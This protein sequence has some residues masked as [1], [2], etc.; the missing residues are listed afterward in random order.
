MLLNSIKINGMLSF[1]DVEL[2]MRPLNVLVGPNASGKSNFIEIM[3]LLQALPRDL[4]G[5][6]RQ[7]GGVPDWLWK[8][9]GP[10]SEN[11]STCSVEAV[12]KHELN[13]S[14][15]S[16]RIVLEK[17]GQQWN[18]LQEELKEEPSTVRGQVES[19]DLVQL[20]DGAGGLAVR[21]ST[22]SPGDQEFI[23][24]QKGDLTPGQSILRE[25]RDP[26][27][28]PEM[29][30]LTLQF[31]SIRLYRDWNMGRNSI[32]RRPQPTDTP[33]DHLYEDFSN[34]ALVLNRLKR[35]SVMPSVDEQL[36]RF[37]E[38][39][40]SLGIDV[41]ANTAQLW[42]REKGLANPVPATRLSDG[43]LR[44]LALLTI[45]CHPNPP[46]LVCI[47]EPELGLHPD[48]IHQVAKL[49]IEASQRTQLIVTTHSAELIDH[50]WEDPESVVVCERYPD[51]GTEFNRLKKE[52]LESYLER[53][54][55]GELWLHGHIG[56]TRF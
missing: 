16:Y 51:T 45:L 13:P 24:I 31:D 48:V 47:E 43:T 50:L 36:G 5:F 10:L 39:Y 44:F 11:Y 18:V 23:F 14:Q 49:L 42:I 22:Q 21:R 27:L 19:F 46:P 55:L 2:E 20:M 15:L 7:S 1:R 56:G 38:T 17:T 53:Y 28:Y 52:E 37:Y 29:H 25:R 30:Y 9:D 54:K 41:L 26:A 8:G 4:A 3:A 33:T 32:I 34:L 6:F 40:E 35:E 12:L